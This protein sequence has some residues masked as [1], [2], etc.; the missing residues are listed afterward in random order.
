MKTIIKSLVVNIQL[1]NTI[2][3]T[4]VLKQ[5]VWILNAGKSKEEFE[6]IHFELDISSNI[7]SVTISNLFNDIDD[8]YPKEI[9]VGLGQ[10]EIDKTFKKISEDGLTV[11]FKCT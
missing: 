11:D 6:L 2:N 3:L 1:V 8:I 5:F 4:K 9:T 10:C 7:I